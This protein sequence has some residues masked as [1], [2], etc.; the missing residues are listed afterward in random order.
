[1]PQMMPKPSIYTEQAIFYNNHTPS[2]G[3]I[4]YPKLL[5]IERTIKH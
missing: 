5:N 3:T 4:S 1:M 2:G